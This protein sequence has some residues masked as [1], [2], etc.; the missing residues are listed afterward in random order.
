M[1]QNYFQ[2]KLKLAPKE[3]DDVISF[4]KDGED[5]ES[6]PVPLGQNLK[7]PFLMLSL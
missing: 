3:N 4:T 5:Q 2:V 1:W 6:K 7:S